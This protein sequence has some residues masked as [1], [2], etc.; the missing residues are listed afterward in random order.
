M[1][2]WYHW[3]TRP[4]FF[5]SVLSYFVTLFYNV[6]PQTRREIGRGENWYSSVQTLWWP[7]RINDVDILTP[8]MGTRQNVDAF[9][10]TTRDSRQRRIDQVYNVW[11][12]YTL[13]RGAQKLR[14]GGYWIFWQFVMFLPTIPNLFVLVS[15]FLKQQ[16]IIHVQL[17]HFIL[18]FETKF[19]FLIYLK[20]KDSVILLW[21][22]IL[23]H[24]HF[25]VMNI[26]S[27]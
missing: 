9:N 3:Y 19:R 25:N 4:I 26:K 11:C 17:F 23:N 7:K 13:N 20:S 21:F 6:W 1:W 16:F 27:S 2:W 18:I 8:L 22:W 5:C 24:S 10:C 14:L 12:F 15:F